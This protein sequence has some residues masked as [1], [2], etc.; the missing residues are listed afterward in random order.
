MI[1]EVIEAALALVGFVCLVIV[2]GFL[3]SEEFDRE[4]PL[5]PPDPYRSALDASARISRAGWE[6]ERALFRAALEGKAAE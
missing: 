3:I 1:V 4:A 2:A 6:A 5:P